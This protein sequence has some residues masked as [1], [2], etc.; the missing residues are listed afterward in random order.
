ML[1]HSLQMYLNWAMAGLERW[2]CIVGGRTDGHC[3]FG[4]GRSWSMSSQLHL[5]FWYNEYIP[6]MFPNFWSYPRFLRFHGSTLV[7]AIIGIW[8]FGSG[9]RLELNWSKKPCV[10]GWSGYQP[11]QDAVGQF[12][13]LFWNPTEPVFRS[14]PRLLAGFP[15]PWPT[16][17]HTHVSIL[18]ARP[19]HIFWSNCCT[20]CMES[21]LPHEL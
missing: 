19:Y 7:F 4:R 6:S 20:H 10:Y 11:R 3:I 2:R 8:L 5:I 13:G 14:K 1:N 12:F 18:N 21:A 16:L 15:D 17:I 9:S